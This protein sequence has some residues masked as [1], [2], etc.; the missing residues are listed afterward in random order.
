MVKVQLCLVIL[1]CL[2]CRKLVLTKITQTGKRFLVIEKKIIQ[3]ESSNHNLILNN[4][5]LIIIY[6]NLLSKITNLETN[7]N[8]NLISRIK[9]LES[10]NRKLT[11]SIVNQIDETATL[12]LSNQNLKSKDSTLSH[13]IEVLKRKTGLGCK[14]CQQLPK[15]ICGECSCINDCEL[16][17]KYYCSCRNLSPKR[18]CLAFH[19]VGLRINGIYT[20][21]LNHKKV[22]EVYCDQTT[23]GGGWTVIQRRVDGTT[24]FYRNWNEYKNGFGKY[25]HEFYLGNENIYILSLQ[26]MQPKGSQLRV[27]IKDWA[28]N[29]AYARYGSFRLGNEGT[30]YQLH[31]TEYSG[32]AGDSLSSEHNGRPF[33]TYDQD[34]DSNNQLS[35][36][37]KGHGAWWYS[38]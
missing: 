33:S 6:Q 38:S 23:D 28:G 16:Q 24:N 30:K 7:S 11:T 12:N 19:Q 27:E 10:S 18:D 2:I 34:N 20:V 8:Q 5:N 37:V 26:A 14:F 31:V 3:L 13:E 1:L 32:N 22:M 4:Q 9:N 17:S 29:T 36:A 25:Q 15:S 21:T 35:C